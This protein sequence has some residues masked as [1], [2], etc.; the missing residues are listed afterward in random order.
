MVRSH[1]TSDLAGLQARG[2]HVQTLRGTLNESTNTL[3]VRV[4]TAGSTHVGVR[5]TLT[6]ARAL[7]ADFT[8]RR[9]GSLLH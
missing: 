9:H 3:N 8:Y 4:P 6:E 5:N 7:A 2:A 1:V